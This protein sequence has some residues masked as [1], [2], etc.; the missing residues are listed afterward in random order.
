MAKYRISSIKLDKVQADPNKPNKPNVGKV[1]ATVLS[2]P[3]NQLLVGESDLCKEVIFLDDS[4]IA[5][6][7][8]LINMAQKKGDETKAYPDPADTTGTKYLPDFKAMNWLLDKKLML[9]K[10]PPFHMYNSQTNQLV[11]MKDGSFKVFNDMKVL[12]P[13][14]EDGDLMKN[15]ENEAIRIVDTFGVWIKSSGETA[16]PTEHLADGQ[17]QPAV[18]QQ[19]GPA[20]T[21]TPPASTMPANDPLAGI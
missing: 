21:G 4:Q 11:T 8:A 7:K 10:L 17:N 18:G 19:Q 1:F 2:A 15:P 12:I 13:L 9:I 16:N 6:Y 5:D 3:A 20:G 14:N